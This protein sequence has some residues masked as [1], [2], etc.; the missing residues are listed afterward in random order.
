[1]SAT[2]NKKKA[3][4]TARREAPAEKNCPFWKSMIVE[5]IGTFFLTLVSA[6]PIMIAQMTGEVQL[7]DKVVP[8]GMLVAAMIYS[9]GAMS[10]AHFNP[11]VTFAFVI[12]GAFPLRD[13]PGYWGSQ[14]LGSI[15]AAVVLLSMFGSV[16]HL[17]ANTPKHGD[18]Q[19]FVFEIIWTYLLVTVILGTA[20]QHKSTGPNAALAVGMTIALCGLVGGPISGASMNPARSFGPALFGGAMPTYWIYLAGPLLGAGLA[21]LVTTLLRG[22]VDGDEER[23]A[24]GEEGDVRHQAH[25]H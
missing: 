15:A 2:L 25:S 11:A 9:V 19:S 23:T 12:R 3:Q 18:I 13:V 10:G 22:P 17:G 21:A 1:M 14:I 16:A 8:A 24:L 5:F 20:Q 7:I 6:A 4:E